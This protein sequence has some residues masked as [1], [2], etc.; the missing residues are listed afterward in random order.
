MR[1]WLPSPLLSASLLLMWL[2]LNQSVA[3]GHWLLGAALGIVAPLLARPLQPHGHA[4]IHRP[5]ALFRLLWFSAIEIVVMD[6]IS[7]M[8]KR[9]RPVFLPNPFLN[10]SRLSSRL[11]PMPSSST[12]RRMPG[13][14]SWQ[15]MRMVVIFAPP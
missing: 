5:L 9:P 10:N 7:R 11:I 14:V 3:P 2:L 13:G 12:I 8:K 15:R 6:R 1:R 4:R